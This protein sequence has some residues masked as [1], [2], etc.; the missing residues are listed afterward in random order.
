MA[1]QN[2]SSHPYS[3]AE[4]EAMWGRGLAWRP[5]VVLW[6][7]LS[8]EAVIILSDIY[9]IEYYMICCQEFAYC[10]WYYKLNEILKKCVTYFRINILPV[11][12]REKLCNFKLLRWAASRSDRLLRTTWAKTAASA[13]FYWKIS[14][15]R[16][17]SLADFVLQFEKFI[18]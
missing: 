7:C 4:M 5:R 6:N 16:K 12:S 3:I 9:D 10:K 1:I 2:E 11:S 14:V 15:M 17:I 18:F 13:H 8:T